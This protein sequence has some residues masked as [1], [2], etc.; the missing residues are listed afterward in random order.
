[1]LKKEKTKNCAQKAADMPKNRTIKRKFDAI[2]EIE[3]V[4][5]RFQVHFEKKW[6]L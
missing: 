3:N 6:D 1:V 5:T 2:I 4:I